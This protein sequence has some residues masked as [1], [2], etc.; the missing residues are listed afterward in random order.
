MRG[1][2]SIGLGV[3]GAGLLCTGI[4]MAAG[5][6]ATRTTR[7]PELKLGLPGNDYGVSQANYELETGK[8]YR[9]PITANGGKEM[10]WE[11]PEFFRNIWIREVRVGEMEVH[12]SIVEHVEFDGEGTIDLY[13]VPVR[14]GTFEWEVDGLGE[15]GM[16]GTITVK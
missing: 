12:T 7:L 2:R 16:K 5:D 3:F 11:A 1:L 10:A 6:L 8:S 13:F 4:A 15:Q 14:T 9:L